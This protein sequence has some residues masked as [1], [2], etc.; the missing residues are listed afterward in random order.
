M[1]R[2][3]LLGFLIVMLP[4]V[5]VDNAVN[6]VEL[7][8]PKYVSYEDACRPI[9]IAEAF[10]RV[11]VI[12]SQCKFITPNGGKVLMEGATMADAT[13]TQYIEE[14]FDMRMPKLPKYKLQEE[15]EEKKALSS[16]GKDT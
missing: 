6:K 1:L 8:K 14:K 15:K 13:A 9:S 3:L 10:P 11:F 7:A 12:V 16:S 2:A 4:F 5:A